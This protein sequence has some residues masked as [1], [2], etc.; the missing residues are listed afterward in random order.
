MHATGILL[1]AGS[2]ER[3]GGA[4]L[5]APLPAGPDAGL[6]IGV[7]ACRHLASAMDV[8]IA[9]VRGGDDAL[10]RGVRAR[11]CARRRGERADEGMGASL[12]AGVAAAPD[13]SG[14]VVALGRHAVDRGVDDFARRAGLGERRGH[15]RARCIAASGGIRWGSRARI[16]PP[17]SRCA[18]TKARA[19]SL[20]AHREALTLIDVEDPGV[21]RD[22]DT[23]A[24]L[25]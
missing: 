20:A 4:K 19:R 2:A 1:A 21:V 14:Y 10:A 5:R 16:A 22:V 17:C 13:A 25:R 18:A 23:P 11:G 9:V 6:A 8:V 12:A 15:R 7:A 3:F 24:D